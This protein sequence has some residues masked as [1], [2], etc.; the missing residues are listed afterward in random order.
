MQ[1]GDLSI[2]LTIMFDFLAWLL[3]HLGFAWLTLHMPNQW[4]A[5]DNAL[6]RIRNWERDGRLW[7]EIFHLKKWKEHLPDGAGFFKHGYAKKRLVS[8]DARNLDRFVLEARRAELTHWLAILPAPLFFL[9][10]P[11]WAGWFMILYALVA[12]L[13]FIL[14]QRYNRPRFSRLIKRIQLRGSVL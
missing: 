1:I 11:P 10:N 7:D 14:L 9:W 5:T 8:V 4:F 3:I 13:P 2:L 12:N 6:F